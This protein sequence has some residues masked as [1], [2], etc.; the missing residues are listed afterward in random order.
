MC[1]AA[2]SP[3]LTNNICFNC[4]SLLVLEEAD[5]DPGVPT[6]PEVPKP[7]S[8]TEEERLTRVSAACSIVASELSINTD[9]VM[10][11]IDALPLY[12]FAVE[13]NLDLVY[14]V[15][16]THKRASDVSKNLDALALEAKCDRQELGKL[17]NWFDVY[18]Y[19]E[20]QGVTTLDGMRQ[21]MKWAN[22]EKEEPTKQ[23]Y[24][25]SKPKTL[26]GLSERE[27]ERMKAFK[28][29]PDGKATRFDKKSKSRTNKGR[30]KKL[31][32]RRGQSNK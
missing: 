15:R 26:A 28:G 1:G 4:D 23:S 20:Q 32:E 12:N 22:G 6:S 31:Q 24:W 14:V 13:N 7:E 8:L 10:D 18:E 11:F 2:V 25:G 30:E 16:E 27:L 9:D 19:A 29:F 17:L 21:A 5:Q 3:C